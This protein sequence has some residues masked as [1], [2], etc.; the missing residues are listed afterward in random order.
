MKI[1]RDVIFTETK[2]FTM[3]MP[4]ILWAYYWSC[5]DD[6]LSIGIP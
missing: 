2:F 5:K 6:I 4:K 1:L 3:N